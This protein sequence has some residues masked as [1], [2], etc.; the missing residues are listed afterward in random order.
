MYDTIERP[1]ENKFVKIALFNDLFIWRDLEGAALDLVEG[2]TV[3]RDFFY[4]H[5]TSRSMIREYK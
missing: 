3:M 2:W 1:A 4:V 5:T